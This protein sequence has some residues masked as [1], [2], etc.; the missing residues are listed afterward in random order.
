MKPYKKILVLLAFLTF[1]YSSV[2]AS[3][4]EDVY[5]FYTGVQSPVFDILQGRLQEAFRRIGKRCEVRSTGSSK[6]ALLLA[7]EKGDG[8][9]YRNGVIKEINPDMTGNL[10]KIPESVGDVEFSVYTNK[11]HLVVSNWASLDGLKNG[12]RVGAKLLENEIPANQTRLPDTDR[13]LKMLAENRLDTVTEHGTIADYKIQQLH[14]Q[15]INK[16]TPPLASF[17]GYSY[18]HKKHKQLIPAI[19]A[20]LAEMKKDGSFMQVKKDAFKNLLASPSESTP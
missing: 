14:L 13:L 16:L 17:P 9:A 11:K 10:L 1:A 15:G 19:S 3:G 8:D 6:R 4:E 20:S 5:I 18:I 7:N 2:I 12:L